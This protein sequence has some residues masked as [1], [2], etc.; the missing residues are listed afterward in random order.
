TTEIH[1][2]GTS[3]RSVALPSAAMRST[4]PSSP[5]VISVSFASS[6]TQ[7]SRPSCASVTFS[8]W[9]RRW[10]APEAVAKNGTSPRKAAAM[11]WPSRSRGAT[12]GIIGSFPSRFPASC[13]LRLAGLER[14]LD[15]LAVEIAADEDEAAFARLAILPGALVVALD[16]HVHA[17]HD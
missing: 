11:T 12:V 7:A 8:P 15:L 9:S 17:L 5:P 3:A 10:M 1:L 16:D 2:R 4:L 14:A 6:R 13:F